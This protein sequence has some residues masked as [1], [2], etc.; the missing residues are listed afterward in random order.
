MLPVSISDHG[1]IFDDQSAVLSGFTWKNT[2]LM[3]RL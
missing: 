1:K 3:P 2:V